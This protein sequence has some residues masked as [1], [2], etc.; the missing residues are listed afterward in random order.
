VDILDDNFTFDIKRAEEILDGL[1]KC[2]P[3]LYINLQNGARIDS[4]SEGLL[5]KMKKAGVFKIGFGI[6]TAD[7]NIQKKVKKTIDLDNAVFLTG[8]ARS[9]GMVIHG[10]FILGLPFEN[11][12]SME[13]TIDFSVR[14]N[15]HFANFSI[16]IPFPG[17]ELFNQIKEN[18]EFLEDVENGIEAG[19]LGQ[20]IF[21]RLNSLSPSD[22]ALSFRQAYRKFY[23]RPSK[24]I[25]ILSTVRSFG[26]LRWLAGAVRG[27]FFREA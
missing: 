13:R 19:F 2:C 23:W 14:M 10:F 11:L 9:L 1:I 3:G 26:E 17:T 20:K 8:I 4:L 5:R 16:C 22:V 18:V 6:E 27:I 24:I 25:D 15:P 21:F 12:R 7:Y